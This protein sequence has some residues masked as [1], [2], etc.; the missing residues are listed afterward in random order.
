MKSRRRSLHLL[1]AATLVAGGLTVAS[2]GVAPMA[3]ASTA[4]ALSSSALASMSLSVGDFTTVTHDRDLVEASSRPLDVVSMATLVS[5]GYSTRAICHPTDVHS[6]TAPIGFCWTTTDDTTGNWYPQGITG[7]GD[8]MNGSDLYPTCDTCAGRKIVAVSWHSGAAYTEF[9]DDTLARVSF[10]DVTNGMADAVYSHALLVEPDTTGAGY[11]AIASHAD[12]IMWYG[13]K[14][15]LVTGGDSGR[16]GSDRVIRVFDV[17]HFWQMTSTASGTVGCTASACSAAYS[18][19][20]LPEIGYYQFPDDH[21]CTPVTG[22]DPCFTSVSLDRSSS[23]DAM[24]TTEYQSG[25]GGRILRWPLD[26]TSALLAPG[27]D[28]QV[29]PSEGWSSPVYLMQGAVMTG[30]QGVI[31]GLC[32]DGAPAVTYMPGG[33]SATDGPYNKSCLHK[34]TVPS[35]RSSLDIHYWTTSPGNS[36]NLSYWPASGDLLLVNEYKG[37]GSSYGSDRLVLDWHCTGLTCG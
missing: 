22:N 25:S 18:K 27:S 33:T 15:F 34:F 21:I 5:S 10:A 26:G 20:A 28:G 7:S 16:A 4:S 31:E 2:I 6:T 11:H 9:G 17:R 8:A 1:A 29:H 24:V 13:N 12:G 37:D 3:K 36:E 30:N 19:F 23:P 32:P 14:L 35:D